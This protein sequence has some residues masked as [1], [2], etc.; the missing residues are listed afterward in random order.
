MENKVSTGTIVRTILGVLVLLNLVLTRLGI[1]P[2]TIGED[3]L[4]QAGEIM[5]EVFTIMSVW[6]YNN[7][8][9]KAQGKLIII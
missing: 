7:S 3:T 8:L 6:W 1:S 5:V 4:T 2:L 9:T